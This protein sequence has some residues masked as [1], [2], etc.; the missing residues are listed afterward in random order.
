[1]RSLRNIA[2]V[3]IVLFVHSLNYGQTA[4]VLNLSLQEARDIAKA[5][6]YQIQIANS[7]VKQAR[8]RNLE[9][10]SA[11][12]PSVSLSEN[13]IKS[14]NPVTV[15]S[16][17][18]KQGIFTQQDFDLAAL[19]TPDALD[20]FTTTFQVQ[21]PLFNLDAV[22]GKSAAGLA[23]K[24]TK[25]SAK[26]AQEAVLLHLSKS[27]YRLILA[28]ENLR[29]VNE[30]VESARSHRDNAKAVFDEGLINQADYLAAEVRLA[31]LEEKRITA[32]HHIANVS[33]A[34]KFVMGLEDETLIVPTDS[35]ALPQGVRTEVSFSNLR[36]SRSDLR[37]IALQTKAANRNLWMKRSSW[38]PRLN[39]FG[40]MEWNASEAFSKDASNWA[41]GFQLQWNLFEGLGKFGRAQEATAQKEEA[42]VRYRQAEEQAKLE[43]RKAQRAVQSAEARIKVAQSAVEQAQESLRIVEERFSQGL[44]K[45]SDL[46]DK[47]VSLTNARLRYLQAKHDFNVAK[48]ELSFALG[49]SQ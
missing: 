18:L 30:A 28:R 35:L 19:N 13:Y 37:A 34:L 1:M 32:D 2:L 27:Y 4:K 48:S 3:S 21:Q 24:A 40:A 45:T 25:E 7:A 46:L 17:K 44:E 8:G 12:L 41:V 36:S 15:F 38:V 33:D 29:A 5:R 6:S 39:A 20:N 49:M 47:E 22:Y 43:V 11:F 42:Q 16:L 10:W 31:E 14:N 9:S 26:R 23:V